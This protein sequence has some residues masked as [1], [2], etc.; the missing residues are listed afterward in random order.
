MSPVIEKYNISFSYSDDRLG[1]VTISAAPAL[2][3]D[4]VNCFNTI[5]A[6]AELLFCADAI[7]NKN[8]YR[9]QLPQT[10]DNN[11]QTSLADGDVTLFTSGKEEDAS[12]AGETFTLPL[13]D[14]AELALAWHQFILERKTRKFLVTEGQ[15][16]ID[17]IADGF[18][19]SLVIKTPVA[20]SWPDCGGSVGEYYAVSNHGFDEQRSLTAGINYAVNNGNDSEVFSAISNFLNLFASGNYTVT[21]SEINTQFETIAYGCMTYNDDVPP[22]DHFTHSIYN[23]GNELH[24]FSRSYATIDNDRVAEY[25]KLIN[26][27]ERPK[28]IVY[29]WASNGGCT[30]PYY[31][32]DGH[33]KLLA[34]ME[35][36][37]PAPAIYI[38]KEDNTPSPYRNITP[39]IT[40]ILKTAEL[41]HLLINNGDTL[42]IPAC[43][44]ENITQAIDEIFR[45]KT[46]IGTCLPA[47]IYKAHHSADPVQKDWA[48]KRLG[49]LAKNKNIGN[50]FYLYYTT[51]AQKNHYKA[52]YIENHADFK[53]W[54]DALL[55]D[56]DLTPEVEQR[57]KEIAWRYKP[58][59]M[60]SQSTYTPSPYVRPERTTGDLSE[61][62]IWFYVRIVL[63]IIFILRLLASIM[64]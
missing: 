16:V 13:A 51:K 31:I 52:F 56:K 55:N 40:G 64:R 43:M 46:R 41:R 10:W 11:I 26:D 32:V 24:L 59:L 53:K 18:A 54:E 42:D 48:S 50:S 35:L 6:A 9:H 57:E 60:P 22:E 12:V 3:A 37:L 34:Y 63:L 28:V 15:G 25:I 39:Q 36:R 23:Y 62:S 38:S 47:V 2:L 14:M 33:H 1:T 61:K 30:C 5:K 21:I 7:L 19:N 44:S 17:I 29:E 4:Y 45:E 49:V 20:V 27:G 58:P 8:S